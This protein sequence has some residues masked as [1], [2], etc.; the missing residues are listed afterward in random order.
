MRQ[1]GMH[2]HH[3]DGGTD[4]HQL[5]NLVLLCLA[6]HHRRHAKYREDQKAVTT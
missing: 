1:R 3:L 4:N 6:C 5:E 2:V